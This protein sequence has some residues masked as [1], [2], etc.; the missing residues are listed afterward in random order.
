MESI[1]IL[2]GGIAQDLNNPKNMEMRVQV[3]KVL[4]EVLQ[5]EAVSATATQTKAAAPAMVQTW[6]AGWEL[7]VEPNQILEL[8]FYGRGPRNSS[9]AFK[10]PNS[11]PADGNEHRSRGDSP[12]ES[13][14]RS[15]SGQVKLLPFSERA[16]VT[17]GRAVRRLRR[18]RVRV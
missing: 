5:P 2:A 13:L 15:G 7:L 8:M 1:G 14:K 11:G 12:A 6:K 16:G 9:M 17:W 3:L 4:R 18:T 10:S